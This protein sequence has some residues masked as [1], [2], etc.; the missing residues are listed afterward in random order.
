MKFLY[1]IFIKNLYLPYEFFIAVLGIAV[2]FV[3]GF[4]WSGLFL[5][6][7]AAL[8][9]FIALVVLEFVILQFNK[10]QPFQFCV[11]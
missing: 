9:L 8:G 5:I 7:Q 4:V 3:L 1:R 6:A 11:T 2:L 10:N